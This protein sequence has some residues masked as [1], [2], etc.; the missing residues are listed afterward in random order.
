MFDTR[1]GI[2]HFERPSTSIAP[3]L[4]RDQFL[5]SS[6]ADGATS[7]VK[8]EP[9]H[10]WKLKGTFHSMGLELILGLW[11]RGQQ[12]VIVTLMDPDP[13]FGTSWAEHSLKR[14]MARKA[15]HDRWLSHSLS[16]QRAFSWGTVW[17]DYDVKA[18]FSDIVVRYAGW[19]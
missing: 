8:N 19:E 13:R 18:G 11:F 7:H 16:E 5:A 15:S 1:T 6:L 9:H 10:S 2:L 17:S 12:L 3:W 14:E 4:T